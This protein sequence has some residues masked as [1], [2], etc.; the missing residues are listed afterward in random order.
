MSFTTI[1]QRSHKLRLRPKVYSI[2]A[3]QLER[4]PVSF[5]EKVPHKIKAEV[6]ASALKAFIGAPEAPVVDPLPV[7]TLPPPTKYSTISAAAV[8][9][10]ARKLIENRWI[11]NRYSDGYGGYCALGAIS[12]VVEAS[13]SD[14]EKAASILAYSMGIYE[15]MDIPT[16]NDQPGMTQ[17]R[18]LEYFDRAIEEAA[19]R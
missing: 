3:E 1:K 19:H 8:L 15:P 16:V 5:L 2:T 4:I 11:R 18:M 10:K 7:R 14:R 9:Q 6:Q 17:T 12:A 13:N